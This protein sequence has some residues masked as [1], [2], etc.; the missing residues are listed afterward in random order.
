MNATV[1]QLTADKTKR[2]E[3]LFKHLK[4]AVGCSDV[5]LD[6]L[7]LISLWLFE[8]NLLFVNVIY[9]VTKPGFLRDVCI[10]VSEFMCFIL[11]LTGKAVNAVEPKG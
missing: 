6:S 10:S 1:S 7:A 4:T 8:L 2:L 3:K 5:I 11:V 9:A